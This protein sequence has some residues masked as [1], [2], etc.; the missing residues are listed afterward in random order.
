MTINE[1]VCRVLVINSAITIAASIRNMS[2][3]LGINIGQSHRIEKWDWSKSIL[4]FKIADSSVTD[5][6]TPRHELEPAVNARDQ[7]RGL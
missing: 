6:T 5:G 7:T 1:V 4:P 2:T 3:N